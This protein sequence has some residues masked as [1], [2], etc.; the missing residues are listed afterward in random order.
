MDVG[1]HLIQICQVAK[2]S[3]PHISPQEFPY[4]DSL[5]IYLAFLPLWSMVQAK[6]KTKQNLEKLSPTGHRGE[7]HLDSQLWT[8]TANEKKK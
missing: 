7:C 4:W 8:E 2:S 1:S 3:F 6:N 5:L